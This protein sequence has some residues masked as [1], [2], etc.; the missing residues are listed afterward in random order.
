MTGLKMV[1]LSWR[2]LLTAIG[3]SPSKF[4]MASALTPPQIYE[5]VRETGKPVLQ[6]NMDS[7]EPVEV[8]KPAYMN[9]STVNLIVA[10]AEP[11]LIV[12]NPE[13]PTSILISSLPAALSEKVKKGRVVLAKPV[14]KI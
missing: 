12:T 2:A 5:I 7:D 14:G 4:E 10:G 8:Y 11:G 9:Y 13:E 1:K 3:I 6:I